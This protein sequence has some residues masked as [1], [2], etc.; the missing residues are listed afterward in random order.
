MSDEVPEGL[1]GMMLREPI[2]VMVVDDHPSGA[3]GSQRLESSG[4]ATVAEA[5]D[6]GGDRA[7]PR[8]VPEVILMD[9]QLPTVPG[10]EA[11]VHRG[12]IAAR[13]GGRGSA[14][15]ENPTPRGREGRRDRLS[16]QGPTAGEI[17]NAVGASA[18][19][20]GVHPVAGQ[21]GLVE[22]RQV[23]APDWRPGPHPRENES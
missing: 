4:V 23:A 1:T 12:G 16:A 15:G 17:V 11:S 8:I 13:Q 2:R 19:E 20:A 21:D 9:L 10:V 5:S 7:S 18:T 14:S 6:G 3:T 22:F